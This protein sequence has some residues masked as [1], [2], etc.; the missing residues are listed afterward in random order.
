MNL[1][2]LEVEWQMPDVK[3]HIPYNPI[4]R[5]FETVKLICEAEVS[6]RCPLEQRAGWVPPGGLLEHLQCLFLLLGADC[7][8][9]CEN[10]PSCA[11]VYV[12]FCLFHVDSY[13]H[14]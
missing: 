2:Y 4:Y 6:I 3:K 5:K 14:S 1:L 11:H 10:P 8:M 7:T 13:V 12:V 9:G